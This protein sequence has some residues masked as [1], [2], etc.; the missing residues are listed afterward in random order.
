LENLRLGRQRRDR[1]GALEGCRQV[2]QVSAINLI[3][4]LLGGLAE[5]KGALAIDAGAPDGEG[6]GHAESSYG[7]QHGRGTE[8]HEISNGINA[9]WR[10]QSHPN[11][12]P[13]S[14]SLLTG[15]LTGNFPKSARLVRF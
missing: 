11:L 12:S 9:T 5:L 3:A 6:L 4:Q 2:A 1:I 13:R 10:T 15:K 8:K 7:H 14:N